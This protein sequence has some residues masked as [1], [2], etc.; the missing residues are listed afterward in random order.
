MGELHGGNGRKDRGGES[1][2]EDFRE[3]VERGEIVVRSW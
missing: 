3:H 1:K 2:K